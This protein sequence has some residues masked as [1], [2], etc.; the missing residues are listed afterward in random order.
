MNLNFLT[1]KFDKTNYLVNLLA[2]YSTGGKA[3]SAE[4]E[5]LRKE[6]LSDKEISHLI[7][8]FVRTNRDLSSFWGFIK[9]K[10]GTY[11]ERR[12]YISEQFTPLLDMLEFGSPSPANPAIPLTSATQD[13]RT[14]ATQFVARNKRKV[15]IVHGRENE[16]KQ[17]IARFIE[18]IGLEPIILH[19]QASSGLTII[20]KIERYSNEADFALVIYTPCD[21]GRGAHEGNQ[22]P[23]K[24]AR[25]NVVFEHG[26]LMAKLGRENVCAL[27]KDEIEI[28]ND[29]SGVVYVGLDKSGTWKAEIAK[30]LRAC[31]YEIKS[32]F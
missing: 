26:Y 28:P 17:E 7:P 4:Y 19:E 29:I 9:S 21:F 31:G 20:E 30:E 6:L 2:S 25:Q 32:W 27:V 11:A 24:R 5:T 13:Q 1:T 22:H 8:A 3:E 14:P 15:F 18:H 16:A 23:K 12:T 10:Y